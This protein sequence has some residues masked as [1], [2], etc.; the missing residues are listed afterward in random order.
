MLGHESIATT[1]VY[2]GL[3]KK[4]QRKMVQDLALVT[5][6]RNLAI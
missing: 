3:A 2:V 1:E 4:V 5:G 6:R